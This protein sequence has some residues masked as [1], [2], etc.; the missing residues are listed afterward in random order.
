MSEDKPNKYLRIG[1]SYKKI[2]ERPLMSGD[3]LTVIQDWRKE[4][5]KDDHPDN[6]NILQEIPKYDGTIVHPNHLSYKREVGGFYNLYEPLP[7]KPEKGSCETILMFL[8][9]IFQEQIEL[10]L[11]Y[12]KL[13]YEKP[14]QMQPVLC[15]ISQLRKTGKTTFLDLLKAM[16]GRNMTINSTQDL[17]SRFNSDLA[18]KIV[19]GVEEVLFEK[20]EDTERIKHLSTSRSFKAEAKGKDREEVNFFAKFI[21][22]SNHEE[23]F[24]KIQPGEDRF[25]VIK[26]KPFEKEIVNL[27][28]QMIKEIPQFFNYLLSRDYSTENKTRMWFEFKDIETEALKK[29]ISYNKNKLEIELINIFLTIMENFEEDNLDFQINDLVNLLSKSTHRADLTKIRK[30]VKEKWKLKPAKNS[31]TYKKYALLSDGSFTEMSE[32][33][34]YFSISKEWI[35]ENFD[36]LMS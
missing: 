33:G 9:H 36:E 19:I 22:L 29:E 18:G 27:L 4:A 3:K 34:R 32:K 13:L 16:Y 20:L 2:V 12:L 10:G 6:K 31:L 26:V 25:W 35:N 5:I 24:L 7:Y 17:Q 28:D 8:N 11:D 14:T 21:L 23:T 1:Y 30:I 15:L